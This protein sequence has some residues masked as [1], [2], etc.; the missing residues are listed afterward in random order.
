MFAAPARNVLALCV[1]LALH[2]AGAAAE[3]GCPATLPLVTQAGT[4]SRGADCDTFILTTG[5]EAA[6][7]K[8]VA[9]YGGPIPGPYRIAFEVQ[10]LD[11]ALQ[12]SIAV[13]FRGAYLLLRQG[14]W[15]LYETE[16]S[17]GASGWREDPAVDL[18]HPLAVEIER[19]AAQ[20]VIRLG[21]REVYRGA[22]KRPGPTVSFDVTGPA[23]ERARTRFA[24]LR[25][26]PL[27]TPMP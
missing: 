4:A 7:S 19:G 1:G 3:P 5:G 26:H 21:G 18:I 25:V 9:A 27:G 6:R 15:G 20:V 11:A 17:F 8:V 22:P 24:R 2:P 13:E 12:S 16:P 23:G 10:R 14:A